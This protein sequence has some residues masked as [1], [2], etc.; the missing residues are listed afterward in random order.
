MQIILNKFNSQESSIDRTEAAN[1]DLSKILDLGY[2]KDSEANSLVYKTG[3]ALIMYLQEE[4]PSLLRDY[5]DA[6]Q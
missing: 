6:F 3:H 2:S 5:L 4:D 1:L